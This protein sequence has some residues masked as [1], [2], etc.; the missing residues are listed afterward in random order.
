MVATDIDRKQELCFRT[1]MEVS[2]R[3]MRLHRREEGKGG[4]DGNPESEMCC[5]TGMGRKC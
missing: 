1:K 4:E 2:K 5:R 3:K